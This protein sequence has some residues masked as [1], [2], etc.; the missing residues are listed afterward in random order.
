MASKSS[1]ALRPF[2]AAV[3]IGR[4]RRRLR[5]ARIRA[6][7]LRAAIPGIVTVGVL[8][9]R[10]TIEIGAVLDVGTLGSIAALTAAFGM[11]RSARHSL[12]KE[13]EELESALSAAPQVDPA[14]A[15]SDRR[16]EPP[17]A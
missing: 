3:T 16:S 1:T 6:A 5:V 17:R 7:V 13:V 4:I 15:E 10:R 2:E 9:L 12:L 8:V 11:L 14:H